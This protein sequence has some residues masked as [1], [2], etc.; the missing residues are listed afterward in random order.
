MSRI[1]HSVYE[2]IIAPIHKTNKL[3][4]IKYLV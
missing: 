3:L 4:Y 2:N 1:A